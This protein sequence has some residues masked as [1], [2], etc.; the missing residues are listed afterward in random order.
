MGT[1]PQLVRERDS[2]L[3]VAEFSHRHNERPLDTI[4]QMGRIVTRADGK[5]LTYEELIASG[6]HARKRMDEMAA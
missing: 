1:L 3:G 5:R 2:S 6:P 4:D